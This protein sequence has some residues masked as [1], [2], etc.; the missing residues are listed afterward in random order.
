MDILADPLFFI[1]IL[2]GIGVIAGIIVGI[3]GGS[4]VVA[5][6]PL[7]TILGLD[8]HTS[9]GT[10]LLIDV[11]AS[12]IAAYTYGQNKHLD[13]SQGIWMAIT[14]VIGAQIGSFFS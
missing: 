11:I 7:L 3:M 10:S 1:P 12:T 6:V 4:G 14:A 13:L 9:I 5:V 2:I 8:V